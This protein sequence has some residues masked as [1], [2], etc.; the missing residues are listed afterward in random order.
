MPVQV[1]CWFRFV[2]DVLSMRPFRKKSS[3]K[4]CSLWPRFPMVQSLKK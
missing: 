1:N 3:W 2:V 4:R